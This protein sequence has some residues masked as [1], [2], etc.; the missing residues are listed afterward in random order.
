MSTSD[1][2]NTPAGT[3]GG[4]IAFSNDNSSSSNWR[5]NQFK[6]PHQNQHDQFSPQEFSSPIYNQ[7]N[8]NGNRR[9]SGNA[10][11]DRGFRGNQSYNR[12]NNWRN[13]RQNDNNRR[14]S[15]WKLVLEFYS[16]VFYFLLQPHNN[17]SFHKNDGGTVDISDYFHPSMIQD[18][19]RHFQRSSAE[20]N[21]MT[22]KK[23]CED[24]NPEINVE[25]EV[26]A[27]SN[28]ST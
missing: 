4:F 12:G 2:T 19:W 14:V 22:D 27:S 17:H 20:M 15:W 28:N 21:V 3:D 24:S 7:R 23:H 18:P 11:G 9:Q 13:N 5:K 8:F 1:D 25:D 10:Y 16:G 26:G 6:S